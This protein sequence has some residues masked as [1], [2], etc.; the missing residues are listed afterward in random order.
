MILP[1]A[2]THRAARIAG[3]NT[4]AHCLQAH[5]YKHGV[6]AIVDEF[7][8]IPLDTLRQ[9]ARWYLVDWNFIFIGDPDGQLLP[10]ADRWGDAQ[11]EKLKYSD[12][13]RTLSNHLFVE[14]SIYRRGTDP[15][16]YTHYTN[17]P[18]LDTSEQTLHKKV[19]ESI[20]KYPYNGED[21]DYALFMSDAKRAAWN[22]GMNRHLANC[23]KINPTPG[24]IHFIEC[25]KDQYG[26]P[27]ENRG[28]TARQYDM[29]M[30][31]GVPV[32]ACTRKSRGDIVNGCIYVADEVDSETVTLHIHEDYQLEPAKYKKPHIHDA[33]KVYVPH[34]KSLLKEK[35]RTAGYLQNHAEKKSTSELKRLIGHVKETQ[36]WRAFTMNFDTIFKMTGNLISLREQDEEDNDEKTSNVVKLNHQD[37]CASFRFTYALCYYS[38]QG[39]TIR[40]KNVMLFDTNHKHFTMRHLNVGLSRATHGKYVHVPTIDQQNRLMRNIRQ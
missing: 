22:K 26:N 38:A 2:F 32:I 24:Q 35:A 34:V 19:A 39:T 7:S 15:D 21:I 40:G 17:L 10:F 23:R 5:K 9:M 20:E 25:E 14:L 18:V 13:M 28:S 33:L 36:R 29:I 12:L 11:I 6:W 37:F 8:Q 3:G 16:L 30:W 27:K 1:M 31:P 4:I